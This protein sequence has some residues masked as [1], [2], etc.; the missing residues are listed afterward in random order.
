[1]HI[2]I[3]AYICLDIIIYNCIIYSIYAYINIYV[4]LDTIIFVYIYI[5]MFIYS[6]K[7]YI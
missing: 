2:G 4:C 7:M 1:M 5:Y 3:Y 6:I